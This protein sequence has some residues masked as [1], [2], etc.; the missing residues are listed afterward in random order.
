MKTNL[1]P[2]YYL[3]GTIKALDMERWTV[4]QQK[5]AWVEEDEITI[6]TQQENSTGQR[7]SSF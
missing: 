5:A 1:H 7:K 2:W 3:T 6:K 4:Q